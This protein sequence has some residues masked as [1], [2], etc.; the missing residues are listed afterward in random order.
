MRNLLLLDEVFVVAD[1][2][3]VELRGFFSILPNAP[4]YDQPSRPMVHLIF[5]VCKG[6]FVAVAQEHAYYGSWFF[7]HWHLPLLWGPKRGIESPA[8]II[9]S[10]P[11]THLCGVS[12][13]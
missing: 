5:G 9:H 7:F 13:Q 2:L 8:S 1:R 10:H 3:Q 11:S 4:I 6:V 12:G